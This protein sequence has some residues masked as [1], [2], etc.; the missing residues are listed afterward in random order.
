VTFGD[1]QVVM[2][3]RHHLQGRCRAL[4]RL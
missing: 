2:I 3:A 1:I 4:V